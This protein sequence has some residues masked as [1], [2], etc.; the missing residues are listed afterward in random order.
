MKKSGKKQVF[1][2]AAVLML[3]A[4]VFF[5]S[6]CGKQGAPANQTQTNATS[7]NNTP[8]TNYTNQTTPPVQQ[9]TSNQCDLVLG[10]VK[11]ITVPFRWHDMLWKGEL[12]GNTTVIYKTE[13]DVKERNGLVTGKFIL[14]QRNNPL[15]L[16]NISSNITGMPGK[17]AFISYDS[18]ATKCPNTI[19][20]GSELGT[21]LGILGIDAK[22]AVTSIKDAS[23]PSQVKTCANA[24]G[25]TTIFILKNSGC[26]PGITQEGNCITIDAGKKCYVVETT[27]RAIIDMIELGAKKG[28]IK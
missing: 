13:I 2:A 20:A 11:D 25:N 8:Q 3:I 4:S 16:E 1:I 6:G 24:D 23:S 28:I 10:T 27:E 9:N 26:N 15:R 7:Q 5:I 21:F 17:K 12:E 22:G 14:T 18:S 19:I